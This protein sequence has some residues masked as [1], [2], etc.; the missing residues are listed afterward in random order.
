MGVAEMEQ[1]LIDHYAFFGVLRSLAFKTM[2]VRLYAIKRVHLEHGIDLDFSK[3]PRL[4]MVQRGLKRF[5]QGPRRKLAISTD[6][7]LDICLNGGLDFSKWDDMLKW[8][9]TCTGFFFLLR[10]QE[11]LRTEHGVDELKCLKT[12]HLS[13]SMGEKGEVPIAADGPLAATKVTMFIAFSK[14]DV[15]GEGVTL[16]L[17]AD[18]G[19]P[20]CVVDMFNKLRELC[21]SRFSKREGSTPLHIPHEVRVGAAQEPCAVLAQGRGATG[22]LQAGGFHVALA[23]GG[24]CVGHVSQ[25]LLRGRDPAAGAVGVRRMEDLHPGQL[26]GRRVDDAADDRALD[27]PAPAPHALDDA[28]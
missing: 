11:Y 6:M 13:F 8:T 4:R 16:Q 1:K 22:R 10:S 17:H 2:H 15:V 23:S 18:P 27:G 3:M 25:R 28:R 19:N 26:G 20:L 9:A 24:R 5:A 12:E 14:T 7:L 21:P